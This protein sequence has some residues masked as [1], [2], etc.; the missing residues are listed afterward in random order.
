MSVL[1]VPKFSRKYCK[2][3]KF[4]QGNISIDS[5]C[6]ITYADDPSVWENLIYKKL[7]AVKKWPTQYAQEVKLFKRIF[8]SK[9]KCR[10]FNNCVGV[11]S[12]LID[13]TY[14]RE[15]FAYNLDRGNQTFYGYEHY[16]SQPTGYA[17]KKDTT[18]ILG[19]NKNKWKKV[20]KALK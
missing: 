15:P 10:N 13:F 2:R 5:F 19:G 3:C 18:I 16:D 4:C 1:K 7:K 20:I 9:R 11:D 14:Q 17:H 8:C 12:C 6:Y